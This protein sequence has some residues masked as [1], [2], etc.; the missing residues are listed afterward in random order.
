MDRRAGIRTP[1]RGAA[2]RGSLD[3]QVLACSRCSM[4]MRLRSTRNIFGA[5]QRTIDITIEKYGDAEGGGFFDRATDAPPME[6][7]KRSANRFRIHPRREAIPSRS[8][9]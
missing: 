6:G 4:L 2:L 5:S 1:H 3:D 8:R 9:H 7:L